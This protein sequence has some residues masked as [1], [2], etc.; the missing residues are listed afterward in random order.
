MVRLLHRA[1]WGLGPLGSVLCSLFSF[2]NEKEKEREAKVKRE[3]HLQKK[4]TK[5]QTKGK[6]NH[7]LK[8]T[9]YTFTK[10]VNVIS[11]LFPG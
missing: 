1:M 10:G 9:E 5:T 2:K 11:C 3:N 7:Q 4:H 8:S 6:P